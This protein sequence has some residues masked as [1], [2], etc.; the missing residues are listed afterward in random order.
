MQSSRTSRST[1]AKEFATRQDV[2]PTQAQRLGEL[3]DD[4]TSAADDLLVFHMGSDNTSLANPIG[5]W[6]HDAISTLA[7]RGF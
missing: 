2:E 6:I 7:R 3:G 5:V 4:R 1:A